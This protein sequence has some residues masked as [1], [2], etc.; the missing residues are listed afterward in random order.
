MKSS[1]A[2]GA[3]YS[4]E[5]S[6][7]EVLAR[8]PVRSA[9]LSAVWR[10]ASVPSFSEAAARHGVSAWVVDALTAATLDPGPRLLSDA[11]ATITSAH[12]TRRLT[13]QVFDA[14]SKAGVVPLALKGS[15]L[16]AR[17]YPSNPLCRPSSDVDVLVRID[18]LEPVGRALEA[19]GLHKQ[20]DTSLGDVFED[21]HHVSYGGQAGLVEVHF[22]LTS[23]FGRGLFDDDAIRQRALP[24]VF[25]GHRVLVLA[26][27]D[28]FLYLATH[29]ANHTFLR[30]SWLVDLQQFL[31]LSPTLDFE[32]MAERA[33]RAGFL[34][35]VTISLR[36]L[37][38]LLG[39]R[40]PPSAQGAFSGR[41]L[42]SVID[43]RL[44]SAARLESASLSTHRLGSFAARLWMVDSVG[45]GARHIVDGMKRMARRS[46]SS[47]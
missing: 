9:S 46:L 5:G 41:K 28:E 45:H 42:R 31:R 10:Q 38:H 25:E 37:E 40:L 4:R 1:M 8:I 47:N 13:L 18:E 30:V 7:F 6:L 14:L 32:V 24:F 2:L 12:R 16:A 21:H 35:A 19:L 3:E 15:V 20:H 22:R 23:S 26:P 11:R 36:L 44:F 27:E 34:Q 17:L 29:A 39:V 43:Q 33:R